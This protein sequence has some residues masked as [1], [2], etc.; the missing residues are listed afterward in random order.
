MRGRVAFT[1]IELLV[2]L[3]IIAL[4]IAMLLP[5]LGKARGS[6]RNLQCAANLRQMSAGTVV[7]GEDNKGRF[8]LSWRALTSA[9][10]YA[11]N[12]AEL[13]VGNDHISWISG[14]LYDSYTAIGMPPDG[15]TCPERGVAYIRH[16]PSNGRWRIGY[17]LMAGRPADQYR[18]QDTTPPGT[19]IWRAPMSLDDA[20]NLVMTSDVNES[21]TINNAPRSSFPH[22]PRGLVSSPNVVNPE[23]LNV[24]GAN[25]AY[26]DTSVRFEPLN[27]LT[28]FSASVG[29]SIRGYWPDVPA[30]GNQ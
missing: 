8:R 3:S 11:E 4:L 13:N 28:A 9:D 17:Y 24:I 23:S 21:G 14:H 7:I 27:N 1:L 20:G 16:T 19:R 2:V 29:G 25:I 15:S 18:H 5:A 26:L 22:S 12:Y 6:A 10:A 30:Y